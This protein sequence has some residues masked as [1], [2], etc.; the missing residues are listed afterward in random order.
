SLTRKGIV[1]GVRAYVRRVPG[2]AQKY[3][4]DLLDTQIVA[5]IPSGLWH[6]HVAFIPPGARASAANAFIMD[7]VE[8][9]I[10]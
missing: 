9:S 5:G 1:E 3:A 8:F 6:A 7:T 2:L 10:R 4:G